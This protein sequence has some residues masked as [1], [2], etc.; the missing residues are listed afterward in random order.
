ML[1]VRLSPLLRTSLGLLRTRRFAEP[2]ATTSSMTTTR[3]DPFQMT[4]ATG[5]RAKTKNPLGI[6]RRR[7]FPNA[8]AARCC[9][10]TYSRPSTPAI[11]IDFSL[12]QLF[13]ISLHPRSR[14]HFEAIAIGRIIVIDVFGNNASAFVVT[15][16]A[17]TCSPSI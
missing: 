15:I 17:A 12:D 1:I 14:L 3:F 11:F 7:L 5:W 9:K 6:S 10:S 2:T 4:R 16:I 13:C 8:M